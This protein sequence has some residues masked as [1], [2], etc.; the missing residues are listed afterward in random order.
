M[1]AKTFAAGLLLSCLMM[2]SDCTVAPPS[3]APEIIWTG[4]PR[5]TSCPFPANSLQTQGDLAADNRRL[6]AALASCGL[7]IEIIKDCQEEHDV[8]TSPTAKGTDRLR[9]A[10]ADQS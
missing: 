6:E 7:Q 1:R 4:C 2:L 10:S 3:V 5:V 8:K 9:A